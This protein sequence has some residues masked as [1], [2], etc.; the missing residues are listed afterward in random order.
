MPI[1]GNLLFVGGLIYFARRQVQRRRKAWS[2]FAARRDWSLSTS[3]S[4]L[5]LSIQEVQ[6]LYQG[7]QVSLLIEQRGSSKKSYS[8]TVLRVDLSR[9]VPWELALTPE[10]RLFKFFGGKDS[11][12]GDAALDSA[13]EMQ[14]VTPAAREL[15]QGARV[16]RHLLEAHQSFEHFSLV[17]GLLEAVHRGV[18]ETPEA[19]ETVVAPVLELVDALDEAARHAKE[20]RA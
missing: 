12:V 6:G 19:L 5:G 16:R 18:P 20:R 15:L 14:G 10:D 3:E 17:G 13:L 11:E 1:A 7:Y 4:F 9:V 2:A 8:V